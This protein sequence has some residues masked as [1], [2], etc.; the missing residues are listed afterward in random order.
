MPYALHSD[1]RSYD[2][3]ADSPGSFALQR[4]QSDTE[5]LA[6]IF[7]FIHVRCSCVLAECRSY[8]ARDALTMGLPHPQLQVV[9][10]YALIC[11]PNAHT[12]EEE[13]RLGFPS[14]DI[15]FVFVVV[16]HI[17]HYSLSCTN[18]WA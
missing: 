5:R 16:D 18:V 14:Q 11:R 7:L 1:W 13:G 4:S 3:L 17:L 8:P 12:R 2:I 10:V 6:V 9:A 15:V